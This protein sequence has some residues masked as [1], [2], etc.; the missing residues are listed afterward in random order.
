[1]S[2]GCWILAWVKLHPAIFETNLDVRTLHLEVR[3]KV[4]SLT[5][6]PK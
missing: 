6:T 1:M 3:K 5:L 2:L 4:D